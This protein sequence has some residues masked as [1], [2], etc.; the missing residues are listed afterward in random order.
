MENEDPE[1][2]RL[3]ELVN[4]LSDQLSRNRELTASLQKQVGTLK[5]QAAQTGSSS[6]LRRFNLDI[7]KETFESA[8]E[9]TN[10]QVI[11]EHQHLT[12]ENKQLAALLK[13]FEQTLDTVMSKFRGHA[14]AAQQHE[15][16]MIRHYE[17]L[18]ASRSSEAYAMAADPALASSN[19]INPQ[20]LEQLAHNLRLALR[21]L[22]G[23]SDAAGEMSA[24][25]SD[26]EHPHADDTSDDGPGDWAVEREAEIQRLEAENAEL[27]RVLGIDGPIE[28]DE[29]RELGVGMGLSISSM[30]TGVRSPSQGSHFGSGSAFMGGGGTMNAGAFQP[31]RPQAPPAPQQQRRN[32][33]PGAGGGAPM[34]RG[35]G[36]G[37]A[38]APQIGGAP[39]VRSQG[40]WA[41][42][43]QVKQHVPLLPSSF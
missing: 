14:I 24:F 39:I 36:V 23:A 12:Q 2:S 28:P 38:P 43:N 8:I 42:P 19:A 30:D 7:S 11:L 4:E 35:M 6:S 20:H 27:R 31:W 22:S 29:A 15:Q 34:G 25:D 41:P 13:E 18:L 5:D 3:W 17:A 1:M 37:L 26:S 40:S 33:L 10:A 16:T 9:R 32:V 21:S